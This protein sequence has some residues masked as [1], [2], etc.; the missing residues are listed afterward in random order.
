MS[1]PDVAGTGPSDVVQET[2]AD[3]AAPASAGATQ[4]PFDVEDATL[5]VIDAQGI[6]ADPASEWG[7]PMWAAAEANILALVEQFAG[8]IVLTRWIPPVGE[9][10]VGSWIDYMEAWPFADRPESDPYFDIVPAL[11]GVPA[12]RIDA[13][14]FGKW[15]Q[16]RDVLG[17]TPNIV[18]IGVST[19][20]CVVST[21]LPAADAGA[22]IALVAD[23][24]AGSTPEN[25]DAAVT[26][27]GL[28]PPQITVVN[29]VD[30]L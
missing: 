23:A 12:D 27:M 4:L 13:P 1:R 7:S 22:R 19:D 21:A 11:A 10:R 30:L 25:H 18:L 29:T 24:C 5:V 3:V 28:Y 2:P 6:F 15:D 9:D 8:R 14:M 26:V 16:L 20:C 17:P